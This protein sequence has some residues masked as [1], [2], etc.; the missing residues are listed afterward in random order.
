MTTLNCDIASNTNKTKQD[1]QPKRF[2]VSYSQSHD[3]ISYYFSV[4]ID[5]DGSLTV[6]ERSF[7]TKLNTSNTYQLT[8]VELNEIQTLLTKLTKVNL[9]ALYTI[10]T[11]N[12]YVMDLP[13]NTLRYDVDGKVGETNIYG[14]GGNN[15][16]NNLI[17]KINIICTKYYG[18]HP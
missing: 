18:R 17:R 4:M 8:N 7:L 16:L 11:E 2:E 9:E 1:D 10:E 12:N 15:E 14:S 5:Q 13:T 3:W 6:H